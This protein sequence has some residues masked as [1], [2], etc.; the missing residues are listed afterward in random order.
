[1]ILVGKVLTYQLSKAPVS[2]K[3][4]SVNDSL[5]EYI[6]DISLRELPLLRQLRDETSQ[7]AQANMQISPEQGQFMGLLARLIGARRYLEVG[8][9]TGYS[10]LAVASNMPADGYIIAC[11]VSVEWTSIARSYWRDAGVEQMI[12]LRLAPALQ[13][14]DALLAEGQQESFDFSFIDADKENYLNYY[15]RVLKLLRP[16]GLV[17]IDNVLWNGGV[18][19]PNRN[20][21]DTV[22]IRDFNAHVKDDERVDISLVPIGD[23]LTLARKR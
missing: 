23:G 7:L 2:N 19:D 9:F 6:L 1:M 22:A 17:A 10:S 14:L 5:Y 18:A 12:D 3:T 16:G 20:D 11:D 8:V 15:A 13:T 21:V 4:I